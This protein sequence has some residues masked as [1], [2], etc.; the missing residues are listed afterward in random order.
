[1]EIRFHLDEHID[2]AVA[3]GLRRRGIDV[4]TTIDARLLSADDPRHLEFALTEGRV[5]VSQDADFLDMHQQGLPHAGIVYSQRGLRSIGELV[6]GLVL[7]HGVLT[8]EDMRDWVEY[9]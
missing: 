7:V 8:A 1:M 9:V 5:V 4:T 6:R 2:P 3:D